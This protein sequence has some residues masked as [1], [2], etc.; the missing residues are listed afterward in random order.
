MK[1]M[2]IVPAMQVETV[3][4]TGVIAE[5]LTIDTGKTGGDA[6]VRQ[7]NG[8]GDIWGSAD[9]DVTDEEW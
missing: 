4:L 1:R 2:Y 6:L 9:E 7:D 5:S 3:A 8:W